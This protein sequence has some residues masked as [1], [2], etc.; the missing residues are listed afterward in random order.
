MIREI[1]D[2]INN[3]FGLNN[4]CENLESSFNNKTVTQDF[5]KNNP[6]AKDSV[7]DASKKMPAM[8]NSAIP[9]LYARDTETVTAPID[10]KA[11]PDEVKRWVKKIFLKYLES[12][13]ISIGLK[14]KDHD[15]ENNPTIIYNEEETIE[16]LA[17]KITI[18]IHLIDDNPCALLK[19]KEEVI[20]DQKRVMEKNNTD[21]EVIYSTF[22]SFE[23]IE[24]LF[25]I[26]YKYKF[27]R[28]C[29]LDFKTQI[30]SNCKTI[31]IENNQISQLINKLTKI[32]NGHYMHLIKDL[33]N[34]EINYASKVGSLLKF[35]GDN[36]QLSAYTTYTR[37]DNSYKFLSN[38]YAQKIHKYIVH[39][40]ILLDALDVFKTVPKTEFNLKLMLNICNDC[41][42]CFT[43]DEDFIEINRKG[44]TPYGAAHKN[45]LSFINNFKEQLEQL[46][47]LKEGKRLGAQKGDDWGTS[48]TKSF[49]NANKKAAANPRG[50]G[51]NKKGRGG[52]N[53]ENNNIQ[54]KPVISP[55]PKPTAKTIQPDK[56]SVQ[57][58]QPLPVVQS[59]AAT[60]AP[61][62][63]AVPDA[64][65]AIQDETNELMKAFLK[66]LESY[67]IKE[68]QA[69][70]KVKLE[71]N[72]KKVA[73][74]VEPAV[75]EA[76][77]QVRQASFIKLGNDHPTTLEK[78]FKEEELTVH[79]NQVKS[80][81]TQLEG[82][83][84]GKGQGSK[85]KIYFGDTKTKQGEKCGRFEPLH[86][87]D[88]AHYLRSQEAGKVADAIK[89]AIA[90]GYVHI[91]T[92]NAVLSDDLKIAS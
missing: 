56:S 38:K 87:G 21:E 12:M 52:K 86:G 11:Y 3:D 19:I 74:V 20:S 47:E 37:F 17:L 14:N 16:E 35:V 50:K 84:K 57:K 65:G 54:T 82:W 51:K 55:T 5:S 92:V 36:N 48:T 71:A 64:L 61:N 75:P 88:K 28:K 32:R 72:L 10:S 25:N 1:I 34:F 66:E 67:R 23:Q 68:K 42:D 90:R 62:V 79:E 60:H 15:Y 6:Q 43:E 58:G 7:N 40:Q 76:P 27:K 80:L 39:T 30:D 89:K 81:I 4:S 59:N 53:K 29:F 83:T 77:I 46:L 31:G 26:N 63:I 91:D 69:Q 73:P 70:E 8:D 33:T 18:N 22:L 44:L 41:R 9:A 78:L 45:V 13:N 2:A 49:E 85:F 24:L